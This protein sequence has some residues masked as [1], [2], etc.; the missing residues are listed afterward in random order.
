MHN[1]YQFE[2]DVF[3]SNNQIITSISISWLPKMMKTMGGKDGF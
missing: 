1:Q 3:A 2:C